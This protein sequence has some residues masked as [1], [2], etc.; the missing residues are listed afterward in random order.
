MTTPRFGY[1]NTYVSAT[2]SA[3]SEAT[4]AP[5]E[6]AYNWLPYDFWQIGSSAATQNLEALASADVTCS[7]GGIFRHN[8]GSKGSTVQFQYKSAGGAWAN[9]ASSISPATDDS[10]IFQTWTSVVQPHWRIQI[11]SATTST[12]ISVLSIGNIFSIPY[13]LGTG[14]TPPGMPGQ[15]EYFTNISEKGLFLGRSVKHVADMSRIRLDLLDP[16]W[17]R[18]NLNLFLEHAETK[19]FFFSWDN[20][21]NPT[22]SAFAWTENKGI[23]PPNYSET[24]LMSVNLDLRVLVK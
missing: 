11:T 2:T 7:Y 4:N 19:P 1:H 22:E 16:S 8:L 23:R 10:V 9:V 13:G 12:F 5:K 14:F 18:N 6:N 15:K 24:N 20:E 3:T 21:N 17:V